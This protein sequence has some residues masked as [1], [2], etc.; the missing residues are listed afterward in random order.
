MTTPAPFAKLKLPSRLKTAL[1]RLPPPPSL[2]GCASMPKPKNARLKALCN[3]GNTS[4]QLAEPTG[5]DGDH[6]AAQK[7]EG[8]VDD[9]ENDVET[10]V[11][12]K[13]KKRKILDTPDHIEEQPTNGASADVEQPRKHSS[14][15]RRSSS[16]LEHKGE[17]PESN[18]AQ[19]QN[20]NKLPEVVRFADTE[21]A[22]DEEAQSARALLQLRNDTHHNS[23]QPS[24]GDDFAVS[25]QLLAES[26]P[27]KSR[28]KAQNAGASGSKHRGR[29]KKDSPSA[30]I[31]AE[32]DPGGLFGVTKPTLPHMSP[33]RTRAN[34]SHKQSTHQSSLPQST[35]N[36]DDIDSGDEVLAPYLQSYEDG[37]LGPSFD[38]YL[39]EENRE[40]DDS[41]TQLASDAF[42]QATAAALR[43]DDHE[44]PQLLRGSNK[45]SK[46]G[47]KKNRELPENIFGSDE[48]I[49]NTIA[50]QPV[51]DEAFPIDPT[52][53]EH[54]FSVMQVENYQ[55]DDP[56][57]SSVAAQHVKPGRLKRISVGMRNRHGK[58]PVATLDGFVNRHEVTSQ[59]YD[60]PDSENA[61]GINLDLQPVPIKVRKKRRMPS[62][63]SNPTSS[64]RRLYSS[65]LGHAE[66]LSQKN[67]T[68]KTGP[69]SSK[70][71]D[72]IFAWRD[73]Y[74]SEHEWSHQ[75]FAEIVQ[76][77]ALNNPT[78]NT[79]WSDVHSL[80]PDRNRQA[81]QKF[82]RRKFHNFEKRGAWTEEEDEILK[83]AVAEKGQSWKAVGE[84][85]G[86]LA[87]DV[88]DRYRNYHRNADNRNTEAWTEQ[89]VKNLVK[90]VGECIWLTQEARIQKRDEVLRQTGVDIGVNEEPDEDELEKLI[91]WQVVSD[92]MGGSR[93][94]LQCSYKWKALKFA[95]R[96]DFT[97]TLRKL[98]RTMERLQSGVI[99]VP[100]GPRKDWRFMQARRRV[101]RDML[102]GDKYDLLEALLHCGASEEKTIVWQALGRKQQWRL[103]WSTAD[104]KAAWAIMKEEVDEDGDLGERYVDVVNTLL[105]KL[106]G[107]EGARLEERWEPG[108]D[109]AA[110]ESNP[111]PAEDVV[112][113][114][115]QATT[116]GKRERKARNG[117]RNSLQS[118]SPG[119]STRTGG[120]GKRKAKAKLSED[121]VHSSDEEEAP[122]EADRFVAEEAVE[123]EEDEDARMVRQ[124]Q[125]L[126]DA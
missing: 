114:G 13:S 29:K 105:T 94:R 111:T 15:K 72:A 83:Q 10:K 96:T 85:C 23:A 112:E 49:L 116:N 53:S 123:E 24:N 38:T 97:R 69:F 21:T 4:S 93:S 89:E 19:D 17:I 102:P 106:M 55:H 81:I 64:V 110:E 121:F 51:I 14:K 84:I 80:L 82:C 48:E 76:A 60:L 61:Q 117:V 40:I 58:S 47:R 73:S 87:E 107:E 56:E 66:D 41:Y 16:G 59:A 126:K 103:R 52:L 26:S 115:N 124:V 35:L 3:M 39:E 22:L 37:E 57:A 125:L 1:Y 118:G 78:L 67:S 90:A 50:N 42:Q 77:N 101:A 20:N 99:D 33:K 32:D 45:G 79:F 12:I 86:R 25:I 43:V 119:P 63:T 68:S 44:L 95:G 113:H 92:R 7:S 9:I 109:D 74:C 11:P 34:H 100:V 5:I 120:K 28:K 70:E 31:A 62:T 36:L 122:V 6:G 88:R 27:I 18:I 91:H 30:A 2:P 65:Q 104:L 75:K 46:K 54:G 71:S 98:K 8:D 108:T